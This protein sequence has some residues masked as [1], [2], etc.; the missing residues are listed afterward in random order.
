MKE[1]IDKLDAFLVKNLQR[2]LVE[3]EKTSHRPGEEASKHTSDKGLYSKPT[4]KVERPLWRTETNPTSNH[5]G[6]GSIP[7]LCSVG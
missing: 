6:A 5:E 4:K 1:N 7:G 3:K 2:T